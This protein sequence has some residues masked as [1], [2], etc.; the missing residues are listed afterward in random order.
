LLAEVAAG[1]DPAAARQEDRK[2]LTFGESIDLYRA[3]SVG[4]KTSSTLKADGGS[5]EH[6]LRR[7]ITGALSL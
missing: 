7:T 4:H 6:R 3:A 5:I 1:R 2:T